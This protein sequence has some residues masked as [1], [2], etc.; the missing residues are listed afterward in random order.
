MLTMHLRRAVTVVWIAKLATMDFNNGLV[1]QRQPPK[2]IVTVRTTKAR[3]RIYAKDHDRVRRRPLLGVTE[4][5][6]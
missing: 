6:R 1:S 4:S 5:I 3:G 2:R